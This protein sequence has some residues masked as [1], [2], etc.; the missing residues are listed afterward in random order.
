MFLPLGF[1]GGFVSQFF[2]SFSLTVTFALLASL[3]VALTVVPVLA[4]FLVDN[5]SHD[6]DESGEPRRSRWIHLYDPAIRWVLR[7]RWTKLG[8]VLAAGVLFIL[9]TS[10]VSQLPTAFIDSGSEKIG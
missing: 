1:A 2:L 6:V 3:V 5:V 4:Y 9:S 8:T 7:S 10:L